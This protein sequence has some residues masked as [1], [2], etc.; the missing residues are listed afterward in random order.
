MAL[1]IVVVCVAALP[2]MG[3]CNNTGY[4]TLMRNVGNGDKRMTCIDQKSYYY[5]LVSMYI[6]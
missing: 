2:S 5:S 6:V 4:S 1:A 3:E